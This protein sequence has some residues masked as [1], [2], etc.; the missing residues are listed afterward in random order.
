MRKERKMKILYCILC[1]FCIFNM[2]SLS[3]EIDTNPDKRGF[4]IELRRIATNLSSISIRGQDEYVDF[5]DSRIKGDSQFILQGAFDMG[6]DYYAARYVIFNA[7]TADYGRTTLLRPQERINNTTIDRII[8]STDYTHRIWYIPTFAGGFEIGPYARA[9]FQTGFEN[10]RKITR[11]NAGI[12]LFDGTYIKDLYLNGFVEKDF[13]SLTQADNYGWEL[14]LRFEYKFHDKSRFYSLTNFRHYLNS[15]AQ[16]S[17]NPLYQLELEVRVDSKIYEKFALAPFIKF[18]A[19][20]GRY[21]PSLGSNL[22]V[23]FSMSFGHIFLDATRRQ[24]I[25]PSS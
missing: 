11:V 8:L 15:T 13:A 25:A 19:L 21:M 18:Y 16:P 24:E 23:G 3:A 17:F 2:Q 1:I 4:H 5:S 20:Q 7:A 6:I 12:K 9:S 22:V 10:P 14:G